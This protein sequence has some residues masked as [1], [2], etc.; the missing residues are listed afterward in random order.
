MKLLKKKAIEKNETSQQ[1]VFLEVEYVR[2][3]NP[4]SG[5]VN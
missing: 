2:D 3:I 4:K 1:S 5:N